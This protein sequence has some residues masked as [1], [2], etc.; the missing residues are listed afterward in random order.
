MTG[1]AM[2][3]AMA[4]AAVAAGVSS[5][6]MLVFS[7]GTMQAL[8]RLPE[9]EAIRAMQAINISVI[10]P[11]FLGIFI[12]TGPFLVTLSGL[13]LYG[14]SP[15]RY[16]L[17]A[18]LVYVVGVVAVTILGNVP[19]N[20]SLA[21]VEITTMGP[22]TWDDYA[23]PWLRCNHTRALAGAFASGLLTLALLAPPQGSL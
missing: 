5:G 17:A 1:I 16:L 9:T 22:G 18:T 19:L 10:N 14:G 7:A 3:L 12:G 6:M 11:L 2:Q 13:D 20:D 23:R 8:S 21:A 4:T 15:N